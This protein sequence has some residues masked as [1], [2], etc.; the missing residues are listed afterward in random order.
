MRQGKEYGWSVYSDLGL[1]PD[2]YE[3]NTAP[4]TWRNGRYWY[5]YFPPIIRKEEEEAEG[6]QEPPGVW[7][8][9]ERILH[10]QQHTQAQ[11]G[12]LPGPDPVQLGLG[13]SR[14]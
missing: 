11:E 5:F 2:P 4:N 9:R 1:D 8:M 6:G 12:L 3:T 10:Q 7:G 13:K 14:L